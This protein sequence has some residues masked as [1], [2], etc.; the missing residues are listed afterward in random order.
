M[1]TRMAASS[2]SLVICLLLSQALTAKEQEAR[3]Y[4]GC[5]LEARRGGNMR[6][7][8]VV[9]VPGAAGGLLQVYVPHCGGHRQG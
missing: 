7:C 1:H 6:P 8:A 5:S 4:N 9:G 2:S 3:Q